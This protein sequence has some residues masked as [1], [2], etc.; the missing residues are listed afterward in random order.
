MWLPFAAAGGPADYLSNL[1]V[2]QNEIFPILSLQAWNIWWLV[3]IAAVG[4][5]YTPDDVAVLGPITFRH[6]GFVITGLLSL[7]VAVLI[8]RD[9][10]PRTFILG[11]AASTLIW[12][13][14]LTQMHE[15]YA[16][17]ALIFL[18]LLIPERRIAWLYLA[19]GVVFTLDLLSAAPPAPIFAEW[20]PFGGIV[21]IIGSFVMIAITFLTLTW[22]TSRGSAERGDPDHRVAVDEGV[23]TPIVPPCLIQMWSRRSR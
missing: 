8:L 22:M 15:R 10:R 23:G 20:L 6:I 13:G 17:G 12:F 21:S 19:F 2:Y 14:F 16:Y 1:A 11:L 18:L 5:S 4:A 9:P 3:Q 7:V